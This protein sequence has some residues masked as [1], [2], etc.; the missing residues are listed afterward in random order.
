MASQ[1]A[2]LLAAM[3]ET[4]AEHTY[5]ETTVAAVV[6]RAGVSRRTFYEHFSS[7]LE[8]FLVAYDAGTEVLIRAIAAA[9]SR[10]QGWR[11]RLR[12]GIDAYLGTLGSSPGF[13][14]MFVLEIVA[15]GDTGIERRR[16]VHRRFVG[17]YRELNATARADEPG[18]RAVA[19]DELLLV[20]GGTEQLVA[21]HVQRREVD[22][23]PGLA[24]AVV[25]VVA[26]LLV[27]P[28]A[29]GI[30]TSVATASEPRGVPTAPR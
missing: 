15:V 26:A 12:G 11:A 22:R 25:S 20:V 21:D 19:D 13:A 10:R 29:S 23:L 16:R 28:E 24:P 18:V 17:L 1:R 6:A 8:C 2:R 14:R 9:V 7:R 27:A 4:A 5:G 3:T 30:R